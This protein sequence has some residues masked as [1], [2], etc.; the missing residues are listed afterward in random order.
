LRLAATVEKMKTKKL[1]NSLFI[2]LKGLAM[3]SADIIP[4]VSGGTIALI[5]DIYERFVFA[6]KSINLRF[7]YYFLL[8][9]KDKHNFK[10]AKDSFFAI[11]FAFLIPLALGIFF[12]FL[13]LANLI[14]HLL[15]TV[16]TQTFAFFFGLIFSS[17]FYVYYTHKN[18]FQLSSLFFA[19]LGIILGFLVVG[20]E[21][22]QLD[23]SPLMIFA[24]GIISFCAMILPGLSGAFVLLVLGQ[25]EFLL[26]ILRELTHFEFGN[27][28]FVFVYGLGG[29]IGLLGFSRVLSFLFS[30]YKSATIAFITGLMIGALRKPGMQIITHQENIIL[31]MIALVAGILVVTVFSM[32][33]LKKKEKITA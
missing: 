8:G 22:I 19:C 18:L 26:S 3:G 31:T 25:Y 32:Y 20:L 10:K 13:T 15:E 12:A 14:G 5:T 27:I 30:R 33:E 16:P 4:G 6:L 9:F 29:I 2:F 11:D 1:T 24:S 17:A 7:L 21:N 28:L 23:H